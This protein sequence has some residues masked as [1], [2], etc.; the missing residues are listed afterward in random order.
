MS[1]VFS[2]V[3]KKDY[4]NACAH[5]REA[6]GIREKL[7]LENPAAFDLDLCQ[8]LLTMIFL[9]V[10]APETCSPGETEITALFLRA[11]QILKKYP[12]VPR[13]QNMLKIVEE[14]K[15]ALEQVKSKK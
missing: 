4:T 1:S 7:A 12:Q 9:Y 2:V 3:S 15:E 11:E 5:L 8:T 10:S 14:L 6:L 13:A